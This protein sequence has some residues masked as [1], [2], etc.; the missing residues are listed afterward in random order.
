MQPNAISLL[1]LVALTG[2]THAQIRIVDE[3]PGT[4]IDISTTGTDVGLVND[5]EVAFTTTIGNSLLPAGAIRIGANGGVR[6]GGGSSPVGAGDQLLANNDDLPAVGAFFL[7]EA[8]LPYW[9][10]LELASGGVFVQ[11]IGSTLI[12]Q[13]EDVQIPGAFFLDRMTFQVQVFSQGPLFAQ[14]VYRS[15]GA[16]SV[17]SQ[18]GGSATVGYQG[19]VG[20]SVQYSFNANN[21]LRNGSV[22]TLVA[23]SRTT[24]VV[25]HLPGTFIDIT[26][27]G[28]TL[29]LTQDEVTAF[30]TTI[31]NGLLTSPFVRIGANGGVLL[32]DDFETLSPN[33]VALP[34]PNALAGWT[35]LLPF[36]DDLAPTLALAGR[37]IAHEQHDRLIVQ[38]ENV[39]F[40]QS[41]GDRATF[42]AQI[43]RDGDVAAQFI[44]QDIESPRAGRGVSA[45]IGLNDLSLHATHLPPSAAAFFLVGTTAGFVA[46]AGGGPGEPVPRWPD[47]PC[48]RRCDPQHRRRAARHRAG[49]AQRAAEPD[50]RLRR[51][52]RS[53]AAVPVL[54]P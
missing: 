17:A 39:G 6:F 12:V 14:F 37:V 4:F 44:Y 35:A 7:Q 5:G 54:A 25:D 51:D 13:W 41:G 36:W 33:N 24:F 31:Q 9:D 46:N 50:R 15:L 27:V 19:P 18:R 43:F 1:T 22:L 34:S 21:T 52:R 40:S 47:R 42:Q 26:G 49:Q 53:D 45:T 10:E 23:A 2:S 11:E 32:E 30:P 29:P 38:W 8:L 20:T 28:T 16:H 3:L 48:G